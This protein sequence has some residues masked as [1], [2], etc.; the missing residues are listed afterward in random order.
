MSLEAVLFDLFDTLLIF[1]DEKIYYPIV[2]RKLYDFLFNNGMDIPFEEF[3]RVYFNIREKI[4]SESFVT[5]EE[6]HFN[7][8]VSQTLKELGFNVDEDDKIVQDATLTFAEEL[9]RYV[10]PDV[11]MYFVLEKIF[12]KYKLGMISNFGIPKMIWDLLKEL[13]LK[14][15]FDV[16]IVSAE[17]K[18]RKPNPELFMKALKILNVEP[19]N[20]IFIGDRLDI[21]IMGAKSVGMKTILI[22][23]RPYTKAEI[24]PDNIIS[25]LTE[26]LLL[27][28]A[29]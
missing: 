26:L 16:V 19:S 22:K 10:R 14:S 8:R 18:I 27:L 1:E 2:L 12:K 28:K 11:N 6:K 13:K 17:A 29:S 9:K 25:N 7:F 15:Y 21:D 23:R 3:C 24:K 20:A 5:L 4:Y